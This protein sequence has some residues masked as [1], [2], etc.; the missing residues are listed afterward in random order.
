MAT[1]HVVAL[2]A[3]E[4][5]E[6]KMVG[7]G[8]HLPVVNEGLFKERS[9]LPAYH[10]GTDHSNQ[11]HATNLPWYITANLYKALTPK[12]LTLSRNVLNAREAIVVSRGSLYEGS[13]R[14]TQPR[15]FPKLSHEKI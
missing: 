3:F 6:Q 1:Q 7:C 14:D 15:I 12:Q 8:V 2:S 4:W 11:V 10:S 13:S 9:G 5:C